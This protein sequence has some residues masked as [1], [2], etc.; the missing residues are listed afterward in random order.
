MSSPSLLGRLKERKLVQWALAYL[1]GGF[2]F[3]QVLDAVA[4]PLSL[5]VAALPK[6]HA[7]D[8]ER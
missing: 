8:T 3:L 6:E 5:S 1:A 4:E 2:V 7:E